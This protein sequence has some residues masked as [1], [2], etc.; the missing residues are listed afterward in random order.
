LREKFIPTSPHRFFSEPKHLRNPSDAAT[1]NPHRL[2]A[3]E[4]PSLPLVE[5]GEELS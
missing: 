1:T 3:R 4:Q 5:Q 2:N